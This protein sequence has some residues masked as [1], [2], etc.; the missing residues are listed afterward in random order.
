M[1][2]TRKDLYK[3]IEADEEARGI[4]QGSFIRKYVFTYEAKYQWFLRHCEYYYNNSHGVKKILYYYYKFRLKMLGL[5]LGF[6]IPLNV[7]GPGLC[8]V[9]AGPV[10]VSQYAKVGANCRIHICVNIGASGGRILLQLL[11]MMFI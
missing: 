11:V 5:K 3:Y 4:K 9:H 2:K 6:S 10:V 7:F 1:I 8:L